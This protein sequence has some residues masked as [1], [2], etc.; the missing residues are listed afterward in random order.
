MN[1][2]PIFKLQ[3]PQCGIVEADVSENFIL[4]LLCD[5]LTKGLQL[6]FL[7]N[8]KKDRRKGAAD[9]LTLSYSIFVIV[10]R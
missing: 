4:V 10:F 5:G 8:K 1:T 3:N 6:D 2:D 7:T 9:S